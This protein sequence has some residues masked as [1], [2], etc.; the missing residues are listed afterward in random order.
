[1]H[2]YH[3]SLGNSRTGAIGLCARI[4][5]SSPAAAIKKLKSRLPETFSVQ[6]DDGRIGEYIEVYINTDAITLDAVDMVN[7]E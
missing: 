7:V 4:R 2:S 3:F 5:A 1:M 6:K